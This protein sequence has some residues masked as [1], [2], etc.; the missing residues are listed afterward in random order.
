MLFDK[1]VIA[2]VPTMKPNEARTFY[3]DILGLM[4]LS[5]DE[6]A[7]QFRANGILLKVVLVR[8]LIPQTF[9]VLGWKVKDISGV[10]KSLN[11]KGIFCEEYEFLRQDS[12]GI[13]TSRGGSKVAWFKDPDGNI[14]SVTEV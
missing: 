6:S 14:L 8:E 11:K 3:K 9:T 12:I 7:L 2:F 13:W 5:E 1:E 4:L 10:I